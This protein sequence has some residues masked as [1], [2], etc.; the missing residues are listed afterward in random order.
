MNEKFKGIFPALLTPFDENDD[1]NTKVLCQLIDYNLEKGVQGFYVCEA[2][3]LR[4][5]CIRTV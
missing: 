3:F 4:L 5:F 2:Y 1:V